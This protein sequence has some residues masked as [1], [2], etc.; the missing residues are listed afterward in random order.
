MKK[1]GTKA[2]FPLPFPK[3]S[4]IPVTASEFQSQTDRGVDLE[5]QR[6]LEMR[7]EDMLEE[8]AGSRARLMAE[9]RDPQVGQVI[10]AIEGLSRQQQVRVYETLGEMLGKKGESG[11]QSFQ[12]PKQKAVLHRHVIGT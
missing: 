9:I 12:S 6:D 8:M 1:A 3:S 7:V 5:P 2:P 4:D 10:R 11:S